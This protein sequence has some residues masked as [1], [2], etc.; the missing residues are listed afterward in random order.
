MDKI[1]T[2]VSVRLETKDVMTFELLDDEST[3]QVMLVTIYRIKP[4]DYPS[5]GKPTPGDKI[6]L[7]SEL[8]T[9]PTAP[10]K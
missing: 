8:L 7:S 2:V 6:K 4:T 1:Y 9:V 3:P 5:L 10:A